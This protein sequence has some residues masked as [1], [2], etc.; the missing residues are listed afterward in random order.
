MARRTASDGNL[1]GLKK[2]GLFWG[3]LLWLIPCSGGGAEQGQRFPA[4]SEKGGGAVV[5]APEPAEDVP[6]EWIEEILE[7]REVLE[8]MEMLE[9]MDLFEPEKRFSPHHF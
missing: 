3:I 2:G 4:E 8:S 7:N 9:S 5:D 1:R 6:L